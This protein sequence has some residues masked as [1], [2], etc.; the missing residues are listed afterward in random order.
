MA[1]REL[2]PYAPSNVTVTGA[3]GT[4]MSADGFAQIVELHNTDAS[5]GIWFCHASETA[6]VNKG[7]YLGPATTKTFV[8]VVPRGGLNAIASV[9]SGVVVAVTKG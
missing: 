4:L 5:N 6:E 1:Q 2:Q 8:D 9:T 7:F 3:S